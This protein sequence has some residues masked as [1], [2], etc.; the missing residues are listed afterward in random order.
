MKRKDIQIASAGGGKPKLS[1]AVNATAGEVILDFS[2]NKINGSR[3]AKG[4]SPIYNVDNK[5]VALVQS[6]DDLA[7]HNI[8]VVSVVNTSAAD[9]TGRIEVVSRATP[10][11]ASKVEI[12]EPFT[13]TAGAVFTYHITI[14]V[15][16]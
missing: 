8:L 9:A 3:V 11:V 7:D 1:I 6:F 15:T 10:Y 4:S 2:V 5:A 12:D 13:L 14:A 16:F